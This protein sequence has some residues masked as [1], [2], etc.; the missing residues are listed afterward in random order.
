M[1][2]K[3]APPAPVVTENI[4]STG[5]QI[6]AIAS[7][8]APFI[9]F[10]GASFFGLLHGIGQIT[11]DANRLIAVGPDGRIANRSGRR[12]PSEK[13]LTRSEEFARRHR[14]HPFGGR[15]NAGRQVELRRSAP[16]HTPSRTTMKPVL[17]LALA[18]ASPAW[19]DSGILQDPTLTPGSVRTTD[20]GEIC[21]T[22]TR[23]LR[24]W[25][26]DRDDHILAEY[27][28][29]VGSHPT[30]EVDHLVPLC[31]GGADSDANLWPEPRRSI[32]PTW[33][34]ERKDDLEARMCS[35]VCAG[36]LDVVEAQ[37]MMAEDWTA[38]YGRF[39]REKHPDAAAE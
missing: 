10:D 23:S 16:Q 13:L 35:L 3:P 17:A 31:L 6:S 18:L 7:A 33:S 30:F 20:V 36:E 12:R 28:L 27:G 39:F 15:T 19:A 14:R 24:H 5:G 34:A 11:L 29:P 2:D 37:R 9:Y 38:A 1:T 25:S 22:D 8:N 4:P 32:E 26:R 21:S